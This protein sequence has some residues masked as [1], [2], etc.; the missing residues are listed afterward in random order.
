MQLAAYDRRLQLDHVLVAVAD[1]SVAA[2]DFES[3][4]GLG[5]VAGGRHPGWGTA[6]RIVPLGDSY[7]ELLAIVDEE[8]GAASDLGR[9]VAA[10]GA[11]SGSR[12]FG[13]AVRPDN[14]DEVALRLGLTIER[15]ARL[16]P[17]GEV[18][19]WRAASIDE[20]ASES[21]LPF[22]IE[23]EEGSAF[24]GRAA[25]IHRVGSVEIARLELRGDVDRVSQWLGDRHELPIS[26]RDGQPAVERVILR[27]SE[28]EIVVSA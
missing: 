20:P 17:E 23:W 8:E 13:W 18:L 24:P 15:G 26:V 16:T 14:L 2:R 11:A 21:S 7:L 3:S 5:S 27:G 22:F 10:A 28:G 1:L 4:H 9:W 6:N 12:P 19:R 25:V